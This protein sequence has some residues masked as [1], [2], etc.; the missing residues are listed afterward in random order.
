MARLLV[1]LALLARTF[2]IMMP[3]SEDM[4]RLK[5]IMA[6][7]VLG[8]VADV[9]DINVPEIPD[10]DAM[11]SYMM[12]NVDSFDINEIAANASGTG[13][14]PEGVSFA[15]STR[16][17][18]KNCVS[19]SYATVKGN[20]LGAIRQ[21]PSGAGLSVPTTTTARPTRRRLFGRSIRDNLMQ[22][23]TECAMKLMHECVVANLTLVADN[24]LSQSAYDALIDSMTAPDEFKAHKKQ[25][26]QTC[27]SETPAELS[28][29]S[30]LEF[31]FK[32][33]GAM[34]SIDCGLGMADRASPTV[35]LLA[36]AG[37]G[38]C[39]S[40]GLQ[41][42]PRAALAHAAC[43]A[44]EAANFMRARLA[45]VVP[46]SGRRRRD[47]DD[48]RAWQML[49]GLEGLEG[50]LG[51]GPTPRPCRNTLFRRCPP[52]PQNPRPSEQQ[53]D[54]AI[55]QA[56]AVLGPLDEMFSSA[57]DRAASVASCY[58]SAMD[59]L[60]ADGSVDLAAVRSS[61]AEFGGSQDIKGAAEKVI[62]HCETQGRT[63]SVA[64][65][66][67]CLSTGAAYAC[68]IIELS[69]TQEAQG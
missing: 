17:A 61:L 64:E 15:D 24:Q 6:S 14:L 46:A 18:V 48:L 5:R 36:R 13:C 33:V 69:D 65:F 42:S 39:I 53:V 44:E 43:V 54:T 30:R 20:P 3:D 67:R 34:S 23:A 56:E 35:G 1:C 8:K 47:A 31:Q 52:P 41:P 9:L 45:A 10:S 60:N 50:L 58:H 32:C 29:R 55:A 2:A 59:S 68:G 40:K 11:T 4:A 21:C 57:P 22:K 49:G 38:K 28:G 26:A 66:H 27:L 19:N 62:D 12:A 25:L 37:A 16:E 51:A 63:S 7:P